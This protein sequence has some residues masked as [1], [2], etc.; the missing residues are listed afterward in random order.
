MTDESVGSR[1]RSVTLVSM[2]LTLDQIHPSR[3]IS[4]PWTTPKT[5]PE[6]LGAA[7]EFE[8]LAKAE[9]FAYGPIAWNIT[10]DVYQYDRQFWDSD[11]Q[12]NSLQEEIERIKYDREN[13][14]CVVNIAIAAVQNT[15]GCKR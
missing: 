2:S 7:T 14:Q 13:P 8:N 11:T 15:C 5:D 3:A 6:K 1:P 12:D 9:M 10:M 4:R